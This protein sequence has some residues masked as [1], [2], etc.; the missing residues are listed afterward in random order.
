MPHR[1]IKMREKKHGGK[2]TILVHRDTCYI[3]SLKII[4]WDFKNVL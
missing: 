2:E 3:L 4:F 1:D